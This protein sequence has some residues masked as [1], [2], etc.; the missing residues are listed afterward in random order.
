MGINPIV[1]EFGALE[2]LGLDFDVFVLF[3]GRS[4]DPWD[5]LLEPFP[6][7]LLRHCRFDG[8][9]FPRLEPVAL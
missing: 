9:R 7:D 4:V 8:R 3:A 6:D 1:W 5:L 2:L